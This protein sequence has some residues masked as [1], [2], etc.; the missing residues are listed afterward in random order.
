LQDAEAGKV[1]TVGG[2][3]FSA[4]A[5]VCAD[6][7]HSRTR[8]FVLDERV[9][10]VASGASAYRML[11]RAEDL[12]AIDHPMLVDGRLPP[13]MSMVGDVDHKLVAYPIRGGTLLNIVAYIR[14][15]RGCPASSSHHLLTLPPADSSVH[16]PITEKW[17]MKSS[18]EDLL[19]SY[20]PFSLFWK[21]L[22]A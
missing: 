22:L 19:K 8:E 6:G 2:S 15:S 20:E 9:D 21:N 3:T 16:Q 13:I 5:I 7:I 14:E 1:T 11:I 4:N 18:V 17:T 10:P 12:Q